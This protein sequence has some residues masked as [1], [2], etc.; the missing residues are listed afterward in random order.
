VAKG[1]SLHYDDV[2]LNTL[3]WLRDYTRGNNERPFIVRK[4]GEIEWW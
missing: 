4:N 3:L 2:P 1:N